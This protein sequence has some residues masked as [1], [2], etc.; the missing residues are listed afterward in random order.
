MAIV[1]RFER[2]QNFQGL[3]WLSQKSGGGY[4]RRIPFSWQIL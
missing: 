2:F 1:K 4:R 3:D